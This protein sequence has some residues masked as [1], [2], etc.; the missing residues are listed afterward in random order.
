VLGS[1]DALWVNHPVVEPPERVISGIS[2]FMRKFG[3]V[4]GAFDFAVTHDGEWIM[5][6][7][8]PP[9]AYGWIEDELGFP[10]T[11]TLADVLMDGKVQT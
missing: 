1:L 10:I 3:L 5:F 6:E 2:A 4:F 8:N 9:G 7:C 11:A